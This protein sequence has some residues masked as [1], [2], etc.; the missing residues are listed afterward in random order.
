MLR[1]VLNQKI[2]IHLSRNKTKDIVIQVHLIESVFYSRCVPKMFIM[3]LHGKKNLMK[4]CIIPWFK[5][6]RS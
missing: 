1:V 5:E 2:E 6:F 3:F 4:T